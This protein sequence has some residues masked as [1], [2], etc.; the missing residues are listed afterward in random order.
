MSAVALYYSIPTEAT[1]RLLVGSCHDYSAVIGVAHGEPNRDYWNEK[2]RSSR[3]MFS[4]PVA[5]FDSGVYLY[6]YNM[7]FRLR[8]DGEEAHAPYNT[9]TAEDL[10]HLS[11]SRN[12]AIHECC[13][14]IRAHYYM[15]AG[16][17]LVATGAEDSTVRLW[18]LLDVPEAPSPQPTP[19]LPPSS[20]W[21]PS[22][23]RILLCI[24]RCF[25]GEAVTSVVFGPGGCDRLYCSAGSKVPLEAGSGL[26]ATVAPEH[27]DN[28]TGV[29]SC[30]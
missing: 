17:A 10:K 19:G 8:S 16:E 7:L 1:K 18:E 30:C 9:F 22:K 21:A 13:A 6:I 26:R 5:R 25:D 14:L 15:Q 20:S 24:C 28:V 2:S 12:C 27:P 4:L 3:V 29:G 11:H 23:S